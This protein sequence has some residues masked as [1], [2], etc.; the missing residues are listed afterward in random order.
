MAGSGE[1][2]GEITYL[3]E[4]RPGDGL[5][6]AQHATPVPPSGGYRHYETS[7]YSWM[8]REERFYHQAKQWEDRT[9]EGFAEVAFFCYYPTYD[10]MSGQQL[11][12][13]F[14]WRALLRRGI[15]HDTSLSYLF[16]YVFELINQIGCSDP[17]DGLR[18]LL[19]FWRS[20]RSS[21][22][23]LDRYMPAWIKSYVV[24]FGCSEDYLDLIL[25]IERQNSSK[26][27]FV[28]LLIQLFV[29]KKP[30]HILEIIDNISTYRLSKSKFVSQNRELTEKTLCAVLVSFNE[31][32]SAKGK[33]SLLDRF[34][35][36]KQPARW[37]PF[38]GAVFYNPAHASYYHERDVRVL[39]CFKFF[40]LGDSQEWYIDSPC[41]YYDYDKR[42]RDY[43]AH[44]VKSTELTL[45]LL[46][47]YRGRLRSDGIPP[48]MLS[49]IQK[50]VT[51]YYYMN[52]AS[53]EQKMAMR[54]QSEALRRLPVPPVEFNIDPARLE[55]LRSESDEI[56]DML[57]IEEPE[58][59]GRP[60][61]PATGRE[62]ALMPP[63]TEASGAD[64]WSALIGALSPPR[65]QAL[66]LILAGG[67][68]AALAAL[69]QGCGMM[70]APFLEEINA[71]AV[72]VIGDSVIEP[73]E[74]P[75]IYEEY[76]GEL[77]AVLAQA[78]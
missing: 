3:A 34:V 2:H 56:R 49:A 63:D 4:Y 53:N 37:Y 67:A 8:S 21:H 31:S 26:Y 46:C 15:L 28:E 60:P 1:D 64:E 6:A 35:K 62:G 23:E 14:T 25:D 24:F 55:A 76:E 11:R 12:W 44:I 57:I 30:H 58:E 20:F 19:D 78:E 5:K 33:R 18:K 13:Y 72:E 48:E 16:V 42:M 66:R 73:S 71:I 51:K 41:S 77:K 43:I 9:E 74:P 68:A 17:E 47:G 75:R 69:A 27:L 52:F 10:N 45:R 40:T 22:S 38:S 39:G 50:Y 65:L 61:D 29:Y 70:T 36:L 54:R 59:P 32:I 7:S